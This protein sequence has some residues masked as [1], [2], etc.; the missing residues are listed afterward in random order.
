L[1]IYNRITKTEAGWKIKCPSVE[2]GEVL[3]LTSGKISLCN[4]IYYFTDCVYLPGQF[5]YRYS[6]YGQQ[7]TS[8][9]A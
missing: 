4:H 2:R 1:A 7:I 6:R 5:G 8:M 9:Y 3:L